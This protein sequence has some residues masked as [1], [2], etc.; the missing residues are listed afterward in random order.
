MEVDEI[1]VG[2]LMA[3]GKVISWKKAKHPYSAAMECFAS[4][5]SGL[6]DAKWE[7]HTE[8]VFI[9]RIFKTKDD[10][11]GF[12]PD[13]IDFS[14]NSRGGWVIPGCADIQKIGAALVTGKTLSEG[15]FNISI[16]Q[17]EAVR[18]VNDITAN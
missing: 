17:M 13:L 9:Y 4:Q 8:C 3:G 6:D 5:L 14:P 10:I 1:Y 7:G 11:F 12:N 2:V 15:G 18:T 16:K